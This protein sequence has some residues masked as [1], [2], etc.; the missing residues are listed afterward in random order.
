M[1]VYRLLQPHEFES[2][3]AAFFPL[4]KGRP[5][6]ADQVA[7]GSIF[8]YY[9][10]TLEGSV[11]ALRIIEDR[12]N[13]TARDVAYECDLLEHVVHRGY[14]APMPLRTP[15]GVREFR[16]DGATAILFPWE[17]GE[18]LA[19]NE[20]TP[21]HGLEVG[22]LIARAHMLAQDY[23]STRP[24]PYGLGLLADR[25]HNEM[26]PKSEAGPRKIPQADFD[27]LLAYEALARS[28]WGADLPRGSLH[29]DFFPDNVLWETGARSGA[30]A[31]RPRI[32]AVLDFAAAAPG[33]MMYELG[34]VILAW[35]GDY[36]LNVPVA[37][38][39]YR[40]YESVR[41]LMAYEREALQEGFI[42]AAW[43]Y[44]VS[45][46]GDFELTPA[47]GERI[48]KD[49]RQFLSIF[50]TWDAPTAPHLIRVLKRG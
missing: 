6:R 9:R 48:H 2:I 3:I 39:I 25:L 24:D 11:F 23:A 42:R 5:Y 38:A 18:M 22:E 19:M 20:L 7:A 27:D 1:A 28:N 46:I 36:N 30:R 14:P 29:G 33:P 41:P 8:T 13:I 31:T 37:S 10:L 12:Q 16:I 47:A 4:A 43:R 35:A 34:A 49:Y 45:R 50:R 17:P 32:A 15:E 40:G 44:T 26:I 21:A